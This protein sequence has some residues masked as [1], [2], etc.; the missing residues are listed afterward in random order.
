MFAEPGPLFLGH[1]LNCLGIHWGQFPERWELKERKDHPP[2]P[3]SHEAAD[4]ITTGRY[5]EG[6]S[7][8]TCVVP[9]QDILNMF[10]NNPELKAMREQREQQAEAYWREIGAAPKAESAEAASD[11]APPATDENPTHRED[12]MRLVGAVAKKR[13]Q[14]KQT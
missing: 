2:P 14:D 8:M 10:L 4:L 5:V 11:A 3:S 6:L 13:Q 1:T 12:F 7:G 9:A